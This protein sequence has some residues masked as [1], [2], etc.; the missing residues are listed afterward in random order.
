MTNSSDFPTTPGALDTSLNGSYDVFVTKL[1]ASGTALVYSTYLGGG[2]YDVGYDIAIDSSGN[3]YLTGMTNSSDFPTTPGAWDASYNGGQYD[4]FVTKLN[5]SGSALVYSTYLGGGYDEFGN[6]IAIDSLGNAYLTGETWST[7]F[8][9]TP[10]AF[11][12]SY[13]GDW[14]VFV[15]K[16][17]ASGTA[18]VYSTYLGGGGFEAGNGIAIDSSGN[19]YLTGWTDSSRFPTTPGALDTSYN[20][21]DDVFVT[22][23]SIPTVGIF[24][25]LPDRGVNTGAVP[26]TILGYG[27]Q[28]GAIAK[29]T[30]DGQTDITGFNTVV[31]NDTTLTTVFNVNGRDTDAW[32]VVVV[33]PSGKSAQLDNGFTLL[34]EDVG[35]VLQTKIQAPT[36]VRPGRE[37]PFWLEYANVGSQDMPAPLLIVSCQENIPMRLS[38]EE[39][40]TK[41]TVQVLGVSF[42]STAGILRPGYY[43][44]IPVYFYVPENTLGHTFFHFNVEQMVADNTLIDWSQIE[45]EVHPTDMDSTAWQVI[46]SNVTTQIGSTWLEYQSRLG[47]DATYLAQ[48]YRVYQGG[49]DTSLALQPVE[50]N[51]TVYSVRDLFQFE[52]LKASGLSIRSLLAGSLDAY[53][54]EQ[55]L[56][57]SVSRIVPQPIDQR[58]QLGPLGRGWKHGYEISLTKDTSD[59]SILVKG[60]G[61]SRQFYQNKDGTYQPQTG[62][63]SLLTTLPDGSYSLREKDGLLY[64][65]S[66]TGRLDY[67]AEP[68]GNRLTLGYTGS[69]LT[70][71]IH[72]S[73]ES[74]QITYN[75]QGCISRITDPAGRYVDY[76]YDVGGEHLTEVEELGGIITKY[77]YNLELTSPAYHSLTTII[78]PDTT[79]YYFVY[80]TRG[81][82][83]EEYRDGGTERIQFSYDSQGTIWL[84]DALG[85]ISVVRLGHLGQVLDMQDPGNALVK[86]NYDAKYNLASPIDPTNRTYLFSYDQR[87]NPAGL[88]DALGYTVTMSYTG[89]FNRLNLLE[90]QR[91][92]LTSFSYDTKGNL[93]SIIYQDT[94]NEQFRY[95]SYGNVTSVTNRRGQKIKY[96]YN[97][98]GQITQKNYPDGGWVLYNYDSKG[99]LTEVRD[100][101]GSIFLLYDD[102]RD[103]LKRITYPSGYYFTFQYNDAGQRTQRVDQDGNTLNYYYDSSGRLWKMTDGIGTELIRYEYDST[104]RLNKETKGNGTYTVYSYDSS[105]QIM[106]MVNYAVGGST[107][108][109]FNYTYDSRGNRT[110]MTTLQGTTYYAYD[111]I[112]QL[113]SFRYP[114]NR[115]ETFVYDSA[116]NRLSVTDSGTTT[117]YITNNMNQY[118]QVGAASYTYD[119]DGNMVRKTVGAQTTFY[120]YDIENRLVRVV[121]PEGTWQYT[122]DAL[123]NRVAV[124]INGT[125][126]RYV[127][128]PIGLVDVAAEY[129]GSG[130]LIARYIHGL[131]LVARQEAGSGTMAYYNFD[132]IG[133]TRELTNTTGT[134]LNRYDYSPFGI[135]L[136]SQETVSNP[137][138]YVGRFGVMNDGNDLNFMRTRFYESELGRFV[139]PD[140]INLAG[141][142]NFYAYCE[143]IPVIYI[144]PNGLV[145]HNLTIPTPWGFGV[146]VTFGWDATNYYFGL[147]GTVGSGASAYYYA[148]EN[149]EWSG[150]FQYHNFGYSYSS[151]TPKEGGYLTS[152][153]GYGFGFEGQQTLGESYPKYSWGS[154]IGNSIQGSV[155]Y[156][157]RIPKI[158]AEQRQ[159]IGTKALENITSGDPN[160]KVGPPGYTFDTVNRYIG[161]NDTL[162]YLVYFENITTASAPVQEVKVT[163][164]LDSDLDWSTYQIR[165]ISFGKYNVAIAEDT[166]EYYTRVNIPDW[167]QDTTKEWWVE[168]TAKFNPGTGLATW[169]LTVL[170]PETGQLPEDALAG[171]LPPWATDS[172][173]RQGYISFRVKPKSTLNAGTQIT[174]YATIQFD[175]ESTIN[176]NTWLNTIADLPPDAPQF[177]QPANGAANV[178]INIV[179]QWDEPNRATSYELYFWKQGESKPVSPTASNLTTI[180]WNPPGYLMYRI[181]YYWEVVAKNMF[182]MGT[183][184]E[185]QFTTEHEPAGNQY[186]DFANSDTLSYWYFEK[187]GDGT[188]AGTLS[189]ASV[190]WLGKLGV[191]QITQKPGEK[192]KLTQVF[193]V[194]SS[195]WYTAIAQVATNVTEASKQ[196][197]VYLYLQELASDTSIIATGNQV[198]QP[199]A[200]GFGGSGIWKQMQISFYAQHTLLGVQVVGINP[201]SSGVTGG[202]YL[203]DVW[204][205]AGGPQ[206]TK[207]IALA[208]PSFTSNTS[209]WML[210]VYGDSTGTGTWSWASS[211]SWHTGVLKGVQIGGQK[212]QE[213]QSFSFANNENQALGSVWVYSGATSKSNTQKVYL[214]LYSTDTVPGKI[215][216]SGNA[217]LQ[218]GKWTPGIWQQVQFGY[219]PFTINNTVQLVAINP[220]GKPTQSIYFDTV[221]VKQD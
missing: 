123:G 87:G 209:G 51:K 58:M 22:K 201:S 151:G 192:G 62:D 154:Q 134:I 28:T 56:A 81:R 188:A 110:L 197:K 184:A 59:N 6:G 169:T 86:L 98:R 111:A 38:A 129:N 26:V 84:T 219:T 196:Q 138:Q 55:G 32:N 16:L 198:V 150:G 140:L 36:S 34:S 88:R 7:D 137:F 54:S 33:N 202:F 21:N 124:T 142:I 71:I 166:Q 37:Y 49:I 76:R 107:T 9:T 170:D 18:L 92:K 17:N 14:D 204:V 67:I 146:K 180:Y 112:S 39:A 119:A 8:P 164:Q 194:P 133:H 19:A 191:V 216:E 208:N 82:L 177:P 72:T 217:I 149:G 53:M 114:D 46:W 182:G 143:N 23:I 24:S 152:S 118:A 97:T 127:H 66:T 155:G 131:G 132:A 94:T 73:G 189:W 102:P 60:P 176:T 116:G 193:S 106:S 43:Y 91:Q 2:S 213:S 63:Y 64:H 160:E 78:Y 115:L 100:T 190:S 186:G 212:A 27:F 221:E 203:D 50:R 77:Y 206:P 5:A 89:D 4:V 148:N 104:G 195:G 93:L 183:S 10:G 13:N 185:W 47:D 29:L 61:T 44:R 74:L 41:G 218:P 211:G 153:F 167:R 175:I 108:S 158:P 141:G 157:Q 48:Y 65:F 214:Y 52:L 135:P 159:L 139:S 68:N 75:A 117:N 20:G 200:G 99:R 173:D 125:T 40:Y 165:S 128:D 205:Y 70:A 90:D 144:D 3:A 145:A 210:Q 207:T 199:G 121:S 156:V 105:G 69:W 101:T 85:N 83:V 162:D 136:L 122:Y 35:P 181:K 161:V 178:P 45:A 1:N 30:R 187:Y 15:T 57:L 220:S 95:D 130:N 113:T 96:T 163:D 179:L 147:G 11:D 12:P 215:I 79:A 120:E 168:V 42:D 174:N 31:V 103:F 80:D 109:R 171:I 172:I 25:I 126:R